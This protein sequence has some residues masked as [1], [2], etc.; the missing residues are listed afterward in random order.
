MLVVPTIAPAE[1]RIGVSLHAMI[2]MPFFRVCTSVSLNG[3][4][5]PCATASSSSSIAP[6]AR[7]GSSV[8]K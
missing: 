6:A 2:R 8:A 7:Y 3:D 5:P 1:S 4:G